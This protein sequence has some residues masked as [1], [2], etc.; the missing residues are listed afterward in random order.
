MPPPDYDAEFLDAVQRI[1]LALEC[2]NRNVYRIREMMLEARG[3][4]TDEEG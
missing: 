3:E 4:A 2:L 1:A